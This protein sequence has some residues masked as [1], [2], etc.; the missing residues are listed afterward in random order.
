MVTEE[1]ESYLDRRPEGETQTQ[2]S[3]MASVSV[4]TLNPHC[5]LTFA[6]SAWIPSQNV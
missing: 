3:T 5:G 4:V 6:A 1:P 2:S